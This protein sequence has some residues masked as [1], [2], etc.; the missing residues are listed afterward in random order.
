MLF[1]KQTLVKL[2]H[3]PHKLHLDRSQ[4]V[5]LCS[6]SLEISIYLGTMSKVPYGFRVYPIPTI[7]IH[8][9]MNIYFFW[10]NLE[11]KWDGE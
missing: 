2:Y 8:W 6:R 11:G 7:H 3:L 4:T 9:I 10:E 5:M 1:V